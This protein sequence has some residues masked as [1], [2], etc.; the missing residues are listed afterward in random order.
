MENLTGHQ[1]SA[2]PIDGGQ[3]DSFHAWIDGRIQ[4]P[5]RTVELCRLAGFTLQTPVRPMGS[6]VW[7]P[8]FTVIDLKAYAH[9]ASQPMSGVPTAAQI[10]EEIVTRPLGRAF[11]VIFRWVKRV[12]LVGMVAG[13]CWAGIQMSRPDWRVDL[14]SCKQMIVSCFRAQG[15]QAVTSLIDTLHDVDA[16]WFSG[17]AVLAA[18]PIIPAAPMAISAA[19]KRPTAVAKRSKP[20]PS[21]HSPRKRHPRRR[22]S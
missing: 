20:K 18:E 11:G 7:T 9:P 19:V 6:A 2:V 12:F 16:A 17:P 21:V 22:P 14:A 13:L 10:F 3:V 4:G 8:A 5:Y 1:R 15:H